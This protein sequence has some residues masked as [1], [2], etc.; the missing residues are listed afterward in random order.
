MKEE[1]EMCEQCKKMECDHFSARHLP[2]A[3]DQ[4]RS[5]GSA[6][7]SW[8]LTSSLCSQLDNDYMHLCVE[9]R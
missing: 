8:A 9:D 5:I 6:I 2:L 1:K 4:G 3:R 7:V